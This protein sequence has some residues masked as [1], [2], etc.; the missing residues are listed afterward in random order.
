MQEYY[1]SLCLTTMRSSTISIL[2][3]QISIFGKGAGFL[4]SKQAMDP[5]FVFN[6][7]AD[8][9]AKF[10][11]LQSVKTKLTTMYNYKGTLLGKIKPYELNYPS[12]MV[13]IP[14]NFEIY[15][16]SISHEFTC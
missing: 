2:S 9:H 7:S 15:N 1:E 8:D 11:H 12:I 5:S 6:C 14:K 13:E 4:N 10:L 16:C 3:Q